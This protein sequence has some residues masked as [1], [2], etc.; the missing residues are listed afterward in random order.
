M[1]PRP[2]SR[3]MTYRS[4]SAARR[5]AWKSAIRAKWIALQGLASWSLSFLLFLLFRRYRNGLFRPGPQSVR[6]LEQILRHL[7]VL[8][9]LAPFPVGL[10]RLHPQLLEVGSIGIVHLEIDRVVCNQR[11]E[12]LAG[13]NPE[14]AEHG[15]REAAGRRD[16]AD[17]GR[18]RG[19]SR[20]SALER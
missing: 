9:G 19:S 7:V 17:R 6:I 12:Q 3:S 1:P 14:A 13:V 15:S 18:N 5:V 10:E 2:S 11:E 4:T 16:G 8:H 20:Y